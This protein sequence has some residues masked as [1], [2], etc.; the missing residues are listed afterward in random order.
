MIKD[1]DPPT[2]CRWCE[3]NTWA[4]D[5]CQSCGRQARF[6]GK[7]REAEDAYEYMTSKKNLNH[8]LATGYEMYDN[9][10]QDDEGGE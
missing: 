10:M 6:G 9:E 1:T 7:K 2:I 5:Y 4:M 3:A 8:R